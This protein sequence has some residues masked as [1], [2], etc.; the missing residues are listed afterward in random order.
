MA[1][2]A[3]C[4]QFKLVGC[5]A[6]SCFLQGVKRECKSLPLSVRQMVVQQ[7]QLEAIKRREAVGP[8]SPMSCLL[9]ACMAA[10]HGNAPS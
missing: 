2:L 7:V 9:A 3:G 5:I 6:L 10:A 8:A 4:L 1:G